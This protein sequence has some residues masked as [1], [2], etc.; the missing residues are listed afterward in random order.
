M[1]HMKL[2][3]SKPITVFCQTVCV[4][5]NNWGNECMS[6]PLHSTGWK[7]VEPAVRLFPRGEN[8]LSIGSVCESVCVFGCVYLCAR[9]SLRGSD[10]FLMLHT[11]YGSVLLPPTGVGGGVRNWG[12]SAVLNQ[13]F[14]QGS[15]SFSEMRLSL[16]GRSGGWA[17]FSRSWVNRSDD[18]QIERL[19]TSRSANTPPPECSRLGLN[20]ASVYSGRAGGAESC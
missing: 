15:M 18:E 7:R 8:R 6:A 20:F 19:F 9:D 2:Y 14:L 11:T 1:T 13:N 5:V 17:Q 16:C 12:S 3:S 10:V 4:C